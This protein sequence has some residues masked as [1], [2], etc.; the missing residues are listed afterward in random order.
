M[1]LRLYLYY[2]LL[3]YFALISIRFLNY[4]IMHV[5]YKNMNIVVYKYYKVKPLTLIL[6]FPCWFSLLGHKPE[7]PLLYNLQENFNRNI[8]ALIF[9]YF[10][11]LKKWCYSVY[12]VCFSVFPLP[13]PKTDVTN[14]SFSVCFGRQGALN[15]FTIARSPVLNYGCFL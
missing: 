5:S 4:K 2:S 12:Y 14:L 15:S 1:A 9:T 8:Q 11:F 10:F 7:T 3:Y 6:Y 13:P